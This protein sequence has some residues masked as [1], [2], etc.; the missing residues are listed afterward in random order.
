MSLFCS[1]TSVKWAHYTDDML[2]CEDLPLLKDTLQ[3]SLEH[4]WGIWA[5][6]LQKIQGPGITVKFWWVV[7]S[8][9]CALSQKL[10][11][12]KHNPTWPLRTRKT[13][14]PLYGFGGFKDFYSLPGT[15]PLSLIRAWWKGGTR[16]TRELR[17]K[18]PL[19][20]Q[21]S[22]WSSS[23]PWA[24]RKLGCHLSYMCLWLWKVWAGYCGRD[25]RRREYS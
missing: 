13:R 21:T 18:L 17:S 12:V 19:S 1:P 2:I 24:S 11:L 8:V 3:T 14:K 16:G 20:R 22:E 9:R 10:W 15:V 4:L 25:N 6:N 23:K 5:V 7:W